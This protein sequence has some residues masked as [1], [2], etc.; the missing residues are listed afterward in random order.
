MAD[1]D[2]TR[3][4]LWVQPWRRDAPLWAVE[5][6]RPLSGLTQAHL[7]KGSD[8]TLYV[9]KFQNNPF[10]S[11]I[12]AGEYLATRLGSWL[13]LPMPKV[14][15]IDVPESLVNESLL[16]IDNGN[17]FTRCA[18]GRQLALRYIPDAV[19]SIPRRS[20]DRL[21]NRKDLISVLAFDKWVANCDDRQAVFVKQG[22][23]YHAVFIDQ[24]ECF[25]AGRW[26]FPNLAHHGMYQHR[27][28]Y[29]QVD[30][31]QWFEPTLSRIEKISRFD[32][33]KFATEIPSE[34]YGHQTQ[35]LSRLIEGLY[36]RRCRTRGLINGL[37]YSASNPFPRW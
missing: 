23:Q 31:W 14:Y 16:R 11:R 30:G 8:G 13:G 28:I 1:I 24:H 27:Y 37:R 33:W 17:R 34:W 18:S 12:L 32:L 26:S 7:L 10:K 36:R 4:A 6:V 5:Y 25:D 22:T 19:S 20:F 29:Q 2:L 21:A 15:V 9:T 3:S 35:S